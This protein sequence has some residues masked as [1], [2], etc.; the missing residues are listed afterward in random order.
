MRSLQYRWNWNQNQILITSLDR[1]ALQDLTTKD[2]ARKSARTNEK[3]ENHRGMGRYLPVFMVSAFFF[4]VSCD[5]KRVFDEYKSLPNEWHRDSLVTF[6]FEA[7]DTINNYNLFINLRNNSDYK[8]S[9]LYLIT[10][11]Q[12]PNGKVLSDTLQYEM[13]APSG[14][15]LGTGFGEV[16]ENKLWY[17]ENFQFTEAGEYSV[18]IQQAMRRRDSVAGIER[19]EGITD[20]GFRIEDIK[21]N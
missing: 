11:L 3:R 2:L 5:E 14:E 20:V 15:W 7:P 17:K 8:F 21:N 19:L 4:L 10:Q 9:N 16:K 6:Q 13:A 12:Y 18:N 1:T